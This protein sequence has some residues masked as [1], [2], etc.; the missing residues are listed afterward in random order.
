MG[1]INLRMCCMETATAAE[2]V[3]IAA[4]FIL[5]CRFVWEVGSFFLMDG[6]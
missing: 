5:R 6:D 3:F 4:L 1:D 2:K